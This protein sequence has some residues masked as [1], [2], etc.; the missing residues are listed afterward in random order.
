MPSKTK[1]PIP[2]KE[3]LRDAVRDTQRRTSPSTFSFVV[4][5]PASGR[6]RDRAACDDMLAWA[7]ASASA[8][9]RGLH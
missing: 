1:R 3:M 4:R 5:A 2:T 9:R 6:R 8:R 7:R